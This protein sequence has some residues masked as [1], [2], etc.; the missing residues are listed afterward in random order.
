[1]GEPLAEIG[2]MEAL[3]PKNHYALARI[4]RGAIPTLREDEGAPPERL[5]QAVW[6]HQRVLRDRLVTTDGVPVLVLHPGFWNHEA[7]PDFRGALL[8]IGSA[9]ACTGDIEIDLRSAG[10]QGHGHDTNPAYQSVALHIIWDGSGRG[11]LPTLA[12][13]PVLDSSLPEL[14]SW[15]GTEGARAFPEELTGRCAAPLRDLGE[16]RLAELLD[17]AA[18]VR[19]HAKGARF[20]ARARQAGWEQ[21]L[22]EGAFRALGYKHNVWPMQR[23]AELRARVCPPEARPPLAILQARLLGAGGLLPEQLPRSGENAG[24]VRRLWDVWWRERD[25]FA[26]WQ[27]PASL[28]HLHGLRPANSPHRRLALAAHWWQEGSLPAAIEAWCVRRVARA[29]ELPVTLLE[30]VQAGADDFW[31]RHWTL[32]SKSTPAPQ[33]LLGAPRVTDLA[34]NVVLPWLWVRASEGRNEAVRAEMERRYLTW[35]LGEDNAVLRLARQRLLG[36][37]RRLPRRAAAQQGVLQIVNDFCRQADALCHGCG[38][39]DLAREFG[40]G[41]SAGG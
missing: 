22:W 34:M 31:S 30:V 9:P 25:Q 15:L 6:Q 28:W 40:G 11:N 26:E 23:L 32:R 36:G 37:T 38:F 29:T 27:L 17:Q 1:L 8:Q 4:S 14:A 2:R 35:P 7:G 12:L 16:T 21:A 19:L 20:A 33:P 41:A 39:P 3:I 13:K 24:Y 10:W 5:L 18:L